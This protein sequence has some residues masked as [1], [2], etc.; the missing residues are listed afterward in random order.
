VRSEANPAQSLSAPHRDRGIIA[1]VRAYV[2]GARRSSGMGYIESSLLPNEK[3]V[4]KVKLH[5]IIFWKSSVVTIL[6]VA[7]LLILP[8]V[9]MIVLAIGI[10]GLIPSV[11]DY[12]T[13]E[14]GVTNKRVLSKSDLYGAGRWSCCCATWKRSWS[15]KA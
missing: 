13:S 12:T 9:G 4:Y 7:F 1:P 10:I 15:I 6:G 14:F 5:W 8:I 2:D 3:I 11:V